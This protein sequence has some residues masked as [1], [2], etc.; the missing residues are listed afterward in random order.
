M[1]TQHS[2]HGSYGQWWLQLLGS[3]DNHNLLHDTG[4]HWA[5]TEGTAG[6]MDRLP[7]DGGWPAPGQG[8]LE[9]ALLGPAWAPDADVSSL[10]PSFLR[11]TTSM[12]LG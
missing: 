12:Y 3:L 2:K 7:G 10:P 9:S 11:D 8:L 1:K 6:G 5:Q 4:L